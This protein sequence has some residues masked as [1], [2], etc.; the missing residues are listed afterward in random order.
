M[1]KDLCVMIGA[2]TLMYMDVSQNSGTPKSSILTGFSIINHPF[3]GIPKIDRYIYIY[4]HTVTIPYVRTWSTR[5]LWSTTSGAAKVPPRQRTLSAHSAAAATSWS[6][7][8]LIG[9]PELESSWSLYTLLIFYD[10]YIFL[11]NMFMYYICIYIYTTNPYCS[12]CVT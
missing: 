10:V 5:A 7:V 11:Y 8:N 3:W 4:T 1:K 12:T 2:R 9:V 6:L